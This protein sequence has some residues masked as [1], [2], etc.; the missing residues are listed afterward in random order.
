ME[1]VKWNKIPRMSGD[2]EITEKVDG[3]NAILMWTEEPDPSTL[4]DPHWIAS[5]GGMYLRAGSRTRWLTP[6]DDNFGF[7]GWA[8]DNAEHL[9]RLGPGR[10]FG[11]WYGRGINRGYGMTERRLALFD[12]HKWCSEG[13]CCE[14]PPGVDVVPILQECKGSTLNMASD[15]ACHDLL[16][17]GSRLVPGFMKPEGIVLRY[18]QTSARFKRLLEHDDISKTEAA[19]LDD[20]RCE[21]LVNQSGEVSGYVCSLPQWA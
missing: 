18:T 20:G 19:Q 6:Q 8:Q 3:T 11:E 15:I 10:H 9:V 14:L 7:A 5:A 17:D 16:A 13:E 21:P 2:W 1:F 4:D 12:T